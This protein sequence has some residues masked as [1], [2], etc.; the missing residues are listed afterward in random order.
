[1]LGHEL[2]FRM[3]FI[4]YDKNICKM[5]CERVPAGPAGLQ[6]NLNTIFHF[7]S[8]IINFYFVKPTYIFIRRTN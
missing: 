3:I 1:M 5:P 6:N 7:Y 8:Q 4:T 2:K